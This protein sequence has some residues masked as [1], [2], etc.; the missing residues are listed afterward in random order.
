MVIHTWRKTLWGYDQT[1]I[2]PCDSGWVSYITKLRDKPDFGSSIDWL[3][4]HNPH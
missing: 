2:K 1:H 4:C 3:N